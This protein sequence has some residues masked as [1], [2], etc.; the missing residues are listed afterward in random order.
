MKE[1]RTDNGHYICEECNK[2]FKLK[3]SL[4]SH[5]NKYH[6]S[7]EYFD[8]WLKDNNEGICIICNNETIYSSRLN[9]GYNKFC[10][11]GCF[12]KG[13]NINF[14]NKT[15]E[16]K[17]LIK[18]KRCKSNLEKF[19]V[20]N[21]FSSNII[22]RKINKTNLKNFGFL[23]PSQSKIIKEKIKN[24]CL[25]NFGYENPQQNPE[26]FKKTL[27]TQLKYKRYRDS[28]LIY[29][30]TYE[31]DFLEKYYGRIKIKNGPYIKYIYKNINKVYHSD[32]FI[33]ELNLV[34][35]IKSSY[36]F[37]K[38]KN[39]N[40]VKEEFVKNKGFEYIIIIDKNYEEF[41]KIY[42]VNG[43]DGRI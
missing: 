11:K 28:H 33:K 35:E 37:N 14:K 31:L 22:K 27:N 12:N 25:L 40:L 17:E 38:F 30:G 15:L 7:K 24:S 19:E 16:E 39:Q 32:F 2:K 42:N 23:Y 36:Y 6:N 34:V 8:K 26:I 21:P 10:S 4:S 43:L 5:I 13:M 1:I 9:R 29:Q 41:E 20:I 3:H 18:L